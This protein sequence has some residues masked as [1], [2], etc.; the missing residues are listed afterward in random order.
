[1]K[2]S[3]ISDKV[4]SNL[5]EDAK[6]TLTRLS[7]ELGLRK[8]NY[9]V[10]CGIGGNNFQLLVLMGLEH[11]LSSR[12]HRTI[13]FDAEKNQIVWGALWLSITPMKLIRKKLDHKFQSITEASKYNALVMESLSNSHKMRGVLEEHKS[14]FPQL[15]SALSGKIFK[16]DERLSNLEQLILAFVMCQELAHDLDSGD[17]SWIQSIGSALTDF[18]PDVIL[19]SVRRYIGIDRLVRHDLDEDPIFEKCLRR[20][21]KHID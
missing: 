3:Q 10:G 15:T 9:H 6:K 2:F 7:V 21:N 8:D 4:S 1:M 12:T 19:L 14:Q 16:F 5:A 18:P 20:V 17:R 13:F 11:R